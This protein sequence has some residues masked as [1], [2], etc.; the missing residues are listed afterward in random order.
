M[1]SLGFLMKADEIETVQGEDH[2]VLFRGVSQ[3][4]VI[5]DLLIRS[6]GLV[7]G[8]HVMAQTAEFLDHTFWEILIGVKRGH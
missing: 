3:N 5:G 4:L 7:G 8:E 2:S 1:A 6:A